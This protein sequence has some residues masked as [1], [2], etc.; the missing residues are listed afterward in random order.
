MNASTRSKLALALLLVAAGCAP[1]GGGGDPTGAARSQGS[2]TTGDPSA[3]DPNA[4]DA[5]GPSAPLDPHVLQTA[6]DGALHGQLGATLAVQM[7]G[8]SFAGA[9]GFR[10]AAKTQPMAAGDSLRI[11]SI[12]KTF[13]SALILLLVEDGKLS[14]DD[15]AST[16]YAGV[17]SW[18]DPTTG[19]VTAPTIRNLLDMTSGVVDYPGLQGI[20]LTQPIAPDALLTQVLA[21]PLKFRPSSQWDYSNANYILLGR[22]AE[23]VGGATYASQLHARLL[24]PLGLT[25]TY[26][27]GY[28]TGAAPL[29]RGYVLEADGSFVDV[30]DEENL[31]TA[32][33]DGGLVS[34]AGDVATWFG[35]LFGGQVLSGSSLQQ[36]TTPTTL[37]DA[38]HTVKNY[39]FGM[40]IDST[41]QGPLYAYAGS[42]AGYSSDVDYL[43]SQGL[44]IAVLA[45]TDETTA[46]GAA[47]GTAGAVIDAIYGA[48]Q[49]KL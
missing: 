33:S 45:N 5:G 1:A 32:F 29:D 31:T 9:T 47:N 40:G 41:L 26:L 37:D 13:T 27:G 17:P 38:A 39:G 14:L 4:G 12:T 48:L 15:A 35:A 19:Q 8:A 25:Q 34:T 23:Q 2:V 22:I 30:T 44:A 7:A 3:V 24:D 20:D 11:A 43:P 21:Q 18:T 46:A 42:I 10:D 49:I 36:M 16:Y 6:L 28:E